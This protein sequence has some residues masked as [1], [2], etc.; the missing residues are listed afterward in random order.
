M[1]AH[2]PTV[3][4]GDSIAAIV[5]SINYIWCREHL[6][7]AASCWFECV[8]VFFKQKIFLSPNNIFPLCAVGLQLV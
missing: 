4:L 7:G 3:L 1:G 8:E 2:D 6:N 5:Y